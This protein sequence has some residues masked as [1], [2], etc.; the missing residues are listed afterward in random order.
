MRPHP[1]FRD[2]NIPREHS[3]GEFKLSALTL[4]DLERDFAAVMES[5]ADI[6]A[7]NPTLTWPEGLTLQENLID[8]AWHQK[9]FQ[10][11]RSFAWVIEGQNHHYMGCLY[12]YPS[13]TGDNSADIHWWWRTGVSTDDQS[14]REHLRAWV[15]GSGWPN[16]HYNFQKN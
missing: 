15:S 11:R 16:I 6:K 4:D 8:L 13:I 1:Q 9:E 7:A 10:S 2:Y 5:A 12:I 3:L 14:F